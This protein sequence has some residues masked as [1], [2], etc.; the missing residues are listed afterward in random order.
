MRTWS[1]TQPTVALSVAEAEFYAMVEGATRGIGNLHMLNELG[2]QIVD[3]ELHTDSSS[4]KSFASRRGVGKIRHVDLKELWLQE[5]VKVGKVRLKKVY[6]PNNPADLLTKYLD[7]MTIRR[8]CCLF[9]VGVGGD[10]ETG[11]AA[12]GEC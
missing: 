7:K 3:V 12:E 4:A 6:G 5:A 10:P 2:M 9:D 1:T 11:V 8:L